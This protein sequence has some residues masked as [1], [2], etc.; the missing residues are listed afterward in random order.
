MTAVPLLSNSAATYKHGNTAG[1][2]PRW[3]NFP[4]RCLSVLHSLTRYFTSDADF[5]FQAFFMRTVPHPYAP[6]KTLP[7]LIQYIYDLAQKLLFNC[8][9][10]ALML[11]ISQRSGLRRNWQNSFLCISVSSGFLLWQCLMTLQYIIKKAGRMFV[12]LVAGNV[13]NQ[14]QYAWFSWEKGER[15]S[16]CIGVLWK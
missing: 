10:Q 8:P 13:K 6:P 5:T 7:T 16:I 4:V 9:H 1:L 12:N 14:E 3:I 15:F 11:K 2:S